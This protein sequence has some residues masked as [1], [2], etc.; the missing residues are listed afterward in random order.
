MENDRMKNVFIKNPIPNID[1]S[2][3]ESEKIEQLKEY[4][5][6]AKA[7]YPILEREVEESTDPIKC[8]PEGVAN[9]DELLID[10]RELYQE[11][12][13]IKKTHDDYIQYLKI[14]L[15]SLTRQENCQITMADEKLMGWKEDFLELML[16]IN[17]H[18]RNMLSLNIEKKTVTH[19]SLALLGGPPVTP[20]DSND[21]LKELCKKICGKVL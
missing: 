12:D 20:A 14:S 17:C 6:E 18:Y 13:L 1:T 16:T 19:A 11:I 4:Y 15:I 8:I 7:T 5:E 10:I 3:I 2:R 21:P 9:R